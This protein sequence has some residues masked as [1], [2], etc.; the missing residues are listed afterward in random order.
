MVEKDS[1]AAS[2]QNGSET[3]IDRIAAYVPG[4]APGSTIRNALVAL[5]YLAVP[6]LIPFAFAYAV[7]R[8]KNGI[9]NKSE[10][11]PGFG[12]HPVVPVVAAFFVGAI[13]YSMMASVLPWAAID[14]TGD[15]N[16]EEPA[17]G[18]TGEEAQA[19]AEEDEVDQDG[20]AEEADEN[21][22]ESVGD[23]P[24]EEDER[25][26]ITV[27]V[28]DQDGNAISGANVE[29]VHDDA[30]IFVTRED[31]QTDSDGQVSFETDHDSDVDVNVEADGYED[32]SSSFTVSSEEN[33][34]ITLSEETGDGD[35][36][37]EPAETEESSDENGVDEIDTDEVEAGTDT[38]E[39][40]EEVTAETD[41]GLT[42]AEAEQ[43]FQ[44]TLISE[45]IDPDRAE[46]TE[47]PVGFTVEY[48]STVQTQQ[49]L[50]EEIGYVSG[51]YAAIVGEGQGEGGM[52]VYV[53]N[54][55][56]ELAF[57]YFV[58]D[59]WAQAY[60]DDEMSG[61]EYGERI[62]GTLEIYD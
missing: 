56:G 11:I 28:T 2:S 9:R 7:G 4:A 23:D 35:S 52:I 15:T 14:D 42:E 17:A 43:V 61:E 37:S 40:D 19:A 22:E 32:N 48:A 6:L 13:I 30:I 3:T 20:E 21:V 36:E 5:V 10:S 44:T 38:D 54:P 26:D 49:Q 1:N 58:N 16:V 57:T 12:I 25:H 51:A 60:Y 24:P 39:A 53:Y 18:E 34:T 45:G 47:S 33:I 62:L 31:K 50:V 55:Q 8:N 27:T 41:D 46:H 29:F 59:E